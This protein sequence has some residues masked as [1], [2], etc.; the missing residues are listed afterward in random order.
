MQNK[1]Q[2]LTDKL[3]NE[4]LSKGR[5]E[6]EDMKA[7]AKAEA[8]SI[9]NDAKEKASQ[10]VA[11]AQKEAS[12][13]RTRTENDIKM[14]SSQALSQIKQNIES[15]IILQAI[16]NGLKSSMN[17]MEFMKSILTDIVKSF[18]PDNSEPVSLDIIL[19]ASKKSDLDTF[20]KEKISLICTNGINIKFSD[21]LLSGFKI[22]PSDG[23]Y[24]LSFTGEDFQQI[25]S[26][27]LRPKTRLLLFG[28]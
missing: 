14:A 1:L 13:L 3:Y 7:K 11:D 20:M 4:G 2:E 5:Q 17:D 18:N 21:D 24:K 8:A 25:I 26:G 12:E 23:G 10:I 19:P 15:I 27:Y 16:D 22:G 6:A 9:I 28:E